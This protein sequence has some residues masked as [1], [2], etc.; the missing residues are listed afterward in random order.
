MN[1]NSMMYKILNILF[2]VLIENTEDRGFDLIE[3]R[4]IVML[5]NIYY[6]KHIKIITK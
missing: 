6:S 1:F 2:K 4:F 5:Y 3:A